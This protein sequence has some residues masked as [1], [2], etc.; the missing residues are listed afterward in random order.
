MRYDEIPI[1]IPSWKRW[2]RKDNKTMTIIDEICSE[3]I[4]SRTYLFVRKDQYKQYAESFPHAN[5]V[6]LPPVEGLATTRQYI[7]DFTLDE[8]KAPYCVDVDDDITAMGRVISDNGKPKCK[9]SR[10]MFED[11]L[12]YAA[13]IA[14]DAMELSGCIIG[15]CHRQHFANTEGAVDTAY[16]VNAG[17]T[18]RHIVFQNVQRMREKGIK[19]DSAFDPTGDDVGLVAVCAKARQD[20]F[21]IPCVVYSY[22][23]DSENSVIRNEENCRSLAAYEQEQLMRY[24][25]GRKY[26]RVPFRFE[27]GSYRFSDIDFQKYR[28]VTGAATYAVKLNEIRGLP[29]WT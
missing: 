14:I 19:R 20:F 4:K 27:D 12:N 11:A 25:M 2:D 9:A 5:I 24:P 13:A 10:T 26:M 18:P 22:V 21:H 29:E 28:R 16:K 6:V 23:S 7:A 1:C 15:G 3:Q 17:P 8:L